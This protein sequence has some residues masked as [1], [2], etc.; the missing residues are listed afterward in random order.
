MMAGSL[1]ACGADTVVTPST[2][3]IGLI[4]T[5][6]AQSQTASADAEK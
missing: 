1:G 4:L 2:S 3:I 6:L 5:T